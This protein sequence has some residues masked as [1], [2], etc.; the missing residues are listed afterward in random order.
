M[1]MD[2]VLHRDSNLSKNADFF[3]NEL[4]FIHR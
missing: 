4:N 2:T 1:C 3:S